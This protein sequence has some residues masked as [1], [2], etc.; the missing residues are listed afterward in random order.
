MI[1]HEGLSLNYLSVYN[2][3]NGIVAVV[4][5]ETIK[6]FVNSKITVIIDKKT[7]KENIM[8]TTVILKDKNT[9]KPI[10]IK[11]V[12]VIQI[13]NN[14]PVGKGPEM[15]TPVYP[16]GLRSVTL[17]VVVQVPNVGSRTKEI[18]MPVKNGSELHKLEGC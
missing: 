11:N 12:K 4:S 15:K 10:T 13:I 9:N 1:L 16:E 8:K 3:C 18:V 17:K 2:R 14:R 7:L 5:K 6:K